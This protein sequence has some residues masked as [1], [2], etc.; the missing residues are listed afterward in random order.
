MTLKIERI[1]GIDGTQIRLS[2]DLRSDQLDQVKVEI[3]SGGAI[4]LDVE[5][6]DRVDVESVRFLCA[7]EA[8]GILVLHCSPY[9]RQWILHEQAG[10][11]DGFA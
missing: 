8:A 3:E 2:G 9:I 7:G 4:A 5:E 11:N 1:S 6:I 10:K